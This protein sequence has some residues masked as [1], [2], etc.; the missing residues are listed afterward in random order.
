MNESE[1]IHILIEI[2]S[3]MKNNS[4]DIMSLMLDAVETVSAHMNSTPHHVER[5]LNDVITGGDMR[6][7]L[8]DFSQITAEYL[9]TG[10]KTPLKEL[11]IKNISEENHVIDLQA[12]EK[13]YKRS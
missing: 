2:I 12:I 6:Y 13:W 11:L 7:N 4:G 5:V 8:V 1:K 3:E 9:K 10:N